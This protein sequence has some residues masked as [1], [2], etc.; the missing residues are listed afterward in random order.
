MTHKVQNNHTKEIPT[1]LIKFNKVQGPTTDV[2]TGIQQ[3]DWEPQGIWLWRPVGFDY[4]TPIEVGKQTLGGHKQTLCAPGA[5]G[6]KQCPYKRLSQ[7]CLWCPG[8]S[9][10]CVCL[11]AWSG[12][13]STEYNSVCTNPFEG[14]CHYL[15]YSY[16]SL[17]SG[18]TT[19]RENSPPPHPPINRKLDQRL[20]EHGPAHQNKT[21]FPP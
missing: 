15:H 16:H 20:T 17:A 11:V 1:L 19:R 4:R 5:R 9:G 3:R 21:Q 10:R 2:P 18:Q 7:A 8:V 13:R 6:K 12:V 14:G